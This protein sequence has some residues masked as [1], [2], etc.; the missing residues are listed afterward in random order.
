MR[1][2]I[3]RVHQEIAMGLSSPEFFGTAVVAKAVERL[4]EDLDEFQRIN[5]QYLRTSNRQQN[6]IIGLTV[7]I[8]AL[9]LVLAVDVVPGLF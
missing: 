3:D 8:A 7:V 4:H 6:I 9:T 1:G 2:E 5:Q